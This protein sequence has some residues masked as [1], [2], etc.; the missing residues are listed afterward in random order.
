MWN[1]EPFDVLHASAAL[2]QKMMMPVD[3][4]I[5]SDCFALKGDFADEPSPP[6]RVQIVV[7]GS[8]R[9]ARTGQVHSVIN[10][11]CCGVHRIAHKKFEHCISLRRAAKS[12]VAKGPFNL[13]SFFK[14]FII[15]DY[16]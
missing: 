6:E 12:A 10:L 5:K 3:I 14:H 1:I 16:F 15:L 7:Y 11:L 9:R 4:R 8:A 2:A 13:W